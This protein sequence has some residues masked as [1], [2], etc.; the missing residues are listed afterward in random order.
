MK[1]QIKDSG[2]WRN[3]LSLTEQ[4]KPQVMAAVTS[5]LLVLNQPKT[6]MRLVAN[7]VVLDS[8][9]GPSFLWHGQHT[10]TCPSGDGSLRWPCPAHAPSIDTLEFRRLMRQWAEVE[11]DPLNEIDEASVS[12]N[13]AFIVAHVDAAIKGQPPK[14]V[15]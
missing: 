12:H 11:I 9:S 13:W 7:D 4:E 1:L 2:A 8:C 3:L 5:L 6:A 14:G 15:A 10:C